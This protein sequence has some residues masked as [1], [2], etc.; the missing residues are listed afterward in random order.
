MA[1]TCDE[2]R[3][4]GAGAL[5]ILSRQVN[6]GGGGEHTPNLSQVCKRQSTD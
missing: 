3:Q 5:G 1:E 4:A 6:K 2:K